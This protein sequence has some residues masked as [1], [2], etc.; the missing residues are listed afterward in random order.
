MALGD[1]ADYGHFAYLAKN[2]EEMFVSGESQYPVERVLLTSGVLEAALDGRFEALGGAEA[3]AHA[4]ADGAHDTTIRRAVSTARSSTEGTKLSLKG[5]RLE[6]PWLDVCYRSYEKLP[7][8][9]TGTVPTGALMSPY[10]D[11]T[12]PPPPTSARI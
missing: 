1:R 5:V 8:R 6:T 2:I 7:F 9:P 3:L 12:P 4:G 11:R 10:D